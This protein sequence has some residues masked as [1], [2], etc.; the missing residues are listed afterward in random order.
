[1]FLKIGKQRRQIEEKTISQSV[2]SA[3]NKY[4]WREMGKYTAKINRIDLG[5]NDNT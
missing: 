1:M 4:S 3:G 2:T 5:A